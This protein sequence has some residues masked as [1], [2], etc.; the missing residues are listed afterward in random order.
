MIIGD[1]N[2]KLLLINNGVTV[3]RRNSI[4]EYDSEYKQEVRFTALK[5]PKVFKNKIYDHRD[6]KLIS[7]LTSE[8]QESLSGSVVDFYITESTF[9]LIKDTDDKKSIHTPDGNCIVKFESPYCFGKNS[10]YFL[11]EGKLQKLSLE[12]QK[13][14]PID[15]AVDVKANVPVMMSCRSN[16]N[17]VNDYLVFADY[18]NKI[19]ICKDNKCRVYHWMGGKIQYLSILDRYVLSISKKRDVARFHTSMQRIEPL[20]KFHG[21]F[22]DAICTETKLYLLTNFEFIIFDLI[23]ANIVLKEYTIG[24]ARYKTC[25]IGLSAAAVDSD[26]FKV[27]R[28]TMIE[29]LNIIK[30]SEVSLPSQECIAYTLGRHVF[31][32]EPATR[33]IISVFELELNSVNYICETGFCYSFIQ[34][35]S[36]IIVKTF[37]IFTDRLVQR[38]T[39]EFTW[40][41]RFD[42]VDVFV[43]GDKMYLATPRGVFTLNKMNFLEKVADQ[44]GMLKLMANRLV[45]IDEKGILDIATKKYEI[46]QRNIRCCSSIG[47]L[48]LFYIENDGVYYIKM[49][50]G[51]DDKQCALSSKS[52]IDIKTTV[53]G[54]LLVL[55]AKDDSCRLLEYS[56]TD[57]GIVSNCSNKEN[58][59]GR[60]ARWILT[61]KVCA[62]SRQTMVV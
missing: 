47:S 36:S 25:V 13:I 54:T 29:A 4:I 56:V 49:G 8:S 35:R 21:E 45:V 23:T 48:L 31:I 57:D 12:T 15:I 62:T 9:F 44:K 3:V 53:D 33:K 61:R 5:L 24:S 7:V 27:K 22:E 59:I 38:K 46:Q 16:G 2:R 42:V 18:L 30:D 52:I 10:M 58:V 19:Y 17:G 14:T 60:E 51:N 32:V 1:K 20:F 28:Q 40:K 55:E 41:G 37:K 43:C 34:R 6:H 39:T 26:V 11:S 50:V